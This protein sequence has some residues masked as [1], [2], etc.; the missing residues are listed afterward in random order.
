MATSG[1]DSRAQT[2][3]TK[4]AAYDSHRPTYSAS[5]VDF[6]LE[7]LRVAGKEHATIVDVAAGT[8]KFTEALAARDEK[9]RIIA[10]EP[11]ADMRD[12]LAKKQLDGVTVVD[13]LAGS[14]PTIDDESVDAVTVAQ[15]FHWFANLDSFREI[16]RVLKP[17]GVLGLVWNIE[18]YNAPRDHKAS[19]PWE[20]VAQ[21][22]TF[23]VAEESGDV[24]PRFRH[25]QWRKV[26]DEQIKKTPMSILIASDDQMFSLPIGEHTEP[27]EI[28]L[29][30]EKAWDRYCTLGHIAALEGERLE[31][32][33]KTFMDA[34][35]GP[36]VEKNA[37]GHVIVHGKTHAFW[38]SK[39]PAEGRRGLTKVEHAEE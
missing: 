8:G 32:T 35:S 28:A 23:S 13:G 38:S 18:D 29:S 9:F 4:S 26:F 27:F 31:R 25:G 10:V 6:L 17:H 14:M 37:D 1:L 24:A 39:I 15:G 33:K 30:K 16:H 22:L 19:T 21:D 7:Q 34:I 11:H 20:A 36:D 2:G 5:I 12:V 3:F